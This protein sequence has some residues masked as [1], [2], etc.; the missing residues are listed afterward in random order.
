[1]ILLIPTLT[2]PMRAPSLLA[3]KAPAFPSFLNE[4]LER[5]GLTEPLKTASVLTWEAKGPQGRGFV[6]ALTVGPTSTN[7]RV[8]VLGLGGMMGAPLEAH[9]DA[10]GMRA[11]IAGIPATEE[12][13]VARAFGTYF[14]AVLAG[15]DPSLRGALVRTVSDATPNVGYVPLDLKAMGVRFGVNLETVGSVGFE[16]VNDQGR[17]YRAT[18]DVGAET[19]LLRV[20]ALGYD[21]FPVAP[22]DAALHKD[23]SM[24]A[25]VAGRPCNDLG[26]LL[27]AFGDYLINV[28][29]GARIDP[30]AAARGPKP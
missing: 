24:N 18:I 2:S 30:P 5:A 28:A 27:V 4:A 23:G 6:V 25:L 29:P 3:F 10:Q 16:R 8:D 22:L 13:D 26:A 14:D 21:G 17:G 20:A 15:A 11:A 1:M 9:F 7:V 19:T 12:A